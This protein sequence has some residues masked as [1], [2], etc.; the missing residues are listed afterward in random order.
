MKWLRRFLGALGIAAATSACSETRPAL[1]PATHGRF[2]TGQVWRYRTRP[3]EEASRVII[4][5][6]EKDSQSGTIIHVKLTGLRIPNPLAP[7]GIN[8]ELPHAPVSDA[9]MSASVTDLTDD[10]ADLA[11]FTEGY[12]TWL[13]YSGGAGVFTTPLSEIVTFV[14][15]A[16]R[17]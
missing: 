8:S 12:E 6:I 15:Q 4:G 11:G 17:R 10:V 1:E 5:R 3:G 2:V 14:E 13:Q 16:V 7:G 9:A